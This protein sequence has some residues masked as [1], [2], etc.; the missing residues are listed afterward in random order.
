MDD[1]ESLEEELDEAAAKADQVQGFELH[2]PT[3]D[4]LDDDDGYHPD[5]VEKVP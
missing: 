3:P 2:K 1:P 5:G 4:E